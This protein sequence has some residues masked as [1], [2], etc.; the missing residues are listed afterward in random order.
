MSKECSIKVGPLYLSGDLRL[1]FDAYRASR[2]LATGKHFQYH[3]AAMELLAQSLEGVKPIDDDNPLPMILDR[4][5][6]LEETT[7]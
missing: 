4:L 2:K 3:T 1:K 5:K 6:R 7:P